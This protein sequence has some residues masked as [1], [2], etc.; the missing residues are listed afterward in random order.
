MLNIENEFRQ[1]LSIDL[2]PQGSVCEWCGK[3]AEHELTAL[4]GTY[5]NESGLFCRTCGEA[6]VRAVASSLTRVVSAEAL[7]NGCMY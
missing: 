2:A 6:F 3:P 7:L 4:G 5:H 1:P